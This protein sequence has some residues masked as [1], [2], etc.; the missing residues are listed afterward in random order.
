MATWWRLC[1]CSLGILLLAPCSLS[2]KFSLAGSSR[3]VVGVVGRD[4]VLPCQLTPPARLLGMEVLWR[5]IEPGFVL[6][7]EYSDEGTQGLPGEGYQTRTE[8][9]PQEFSSGN[10]SLKL[11]RLQVADAGTYQCLVRNSEW[12]QEATTELQ[13]AAVAPVLIDVLG[14]RGQGI[15]LICR[16]AGWFPKPELQWVGKNGQ[17]L[18]MEIVTDMTQE[19]EN[20]YSVVS[21]VTVTEGEDNGDISCIV[22]NALLVTER[23]SAIHLSGDVFPRVSPW[24]AAFWV[25]F[26]LFLIAAGACAYLGYTAKRKASQ[27]KRS[28]E[29][30]KLFY[31]PEKTEK[32]TLESEC[33][34]LREKLDKAVTQ[35]EFRR[36]RSYMVL[37]TLDP[38]YKHP[39]LTASADGRTV[40][41]NPPSPGLAAPSAALIAVGRESFVARKDHSGGSGFCRGYWEVEVGDSPDWELGVLSESV[42]DR[43]RQER[44]EKLPEGGC[45][46]LGRSGERYH[47]S[48]ADTVIQNWGVRLTVVGVY[49]DL[50]RGSLSFYS[51]SSMA[52][53]L[54]IPVETSERLFPFLS[55]GHAAGRKPLSICLPSDWDFCQ[56][57]MVSGSVS[58]GDPGAGN[59][60]GPPATGETAPAPGDK[61]VKENSAGPTVRENV[62]KPPPT[63]WFSKLWYGHKTEQEHP[64][65]QTAP[66]EKGKKKHQ[67]PEV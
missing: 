23:Q 6:I 25:I 53:I 65:L 14:P 13:V 59:N 52:L 41:H 34:E 31:D 22:R 54:E 38:D 48:E 24:Q 20:L 51:V 67:N 9:F 28:K 49:L 37:I 39:E 15:G 57:L 56:E 8:L 30:A 18:G 29:E 3:P 58:Q 45:W 63:N 33:Q 64:Q 7:H 12:T 62:Q 26:T 44:L 40:Q 16:T 2:E 27:K 47:P 17:N 5:K 1:V 21:H 32:K 35:L 10:V 66:K 36:A 60:T 55:P 43:V 61:Q 42:R 4:V 50:E 46:A 11:K 19:R